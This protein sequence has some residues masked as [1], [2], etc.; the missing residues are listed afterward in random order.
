MW[1]EKEG[2]GSRKQRVIIGIGVRGQG[3]KARVRVR[4]NEGEGE[5]ALGTVGEAANA[6][7]G[8]ATGDWANHSPAWAPTRFYRFPAPHSYPP[9]RLLVPETRSKEAAP[10]YLWASVLLAAD[11]TSTLT[12]TSTPDSRL[13]ALDFATPWPPNKQP[14]DCRPQHRYSPSLGIGNG[15]PRASTPH[16][17][18]H[19]KGGLRV[20]L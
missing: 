20:R 14:S 12:S 6:R 8:A 1:G 9:P 13:P 15:L 5:V 7:V 19:N 10:D 18:H 11:P 16:P 17:C 4:V 2:L 3:V